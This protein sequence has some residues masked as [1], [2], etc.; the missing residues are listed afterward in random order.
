MKN[1]LCI[2]L[3]AHIASFAQS[4]NL[5]PLAETPLHAI[6]LEMTFEEY[7]D[8]NRR[9]S[10][11]IFW[12]SIPIPGI[13]HYYA[14]EKKKAKTL[15]YI[16]LGGLATM[17][18]GLFTIEEAKWPE[19]NPDIH[20]IHNRG[21][22]NEKRYEKIPIGMEGDVIQYKLNEINKQSDSGGGL[23]FLGVAIL[24][25]DFIYDRFKGLILVEKKRDKVR[26]KY[27]QQIG[28]TYKPELYFS[29]EYGKAG[30]NLGFNL[31]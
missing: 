14:G 19:Y 12:S 13:T 16:G 6:P 25:V 15:F 18:G 28:F 21:D 11:A 7:K 23:F 17:V 31:F 3:F 1:F 10:Q 2:L 30:I 22:E 8:M 4:S 5:N 20:I 27:G 9:F 26:Y 24:A 29:Y